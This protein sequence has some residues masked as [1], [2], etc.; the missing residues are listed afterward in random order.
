[1]SIRSLTDAH[2]VGEGFFSLLERFPSAWCSKT[3]WWTT[4]RMGVVHQQVPAIAAEGSL[5][6]VAAPEPAHKDRWGQ[7]DE[8]RDKQLG[9]ENTVTG[10]C[11]M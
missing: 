7:P 1:M 8:P 5:Q 2:V 9:R 4:A 11:P 3:C 6:T 10:S